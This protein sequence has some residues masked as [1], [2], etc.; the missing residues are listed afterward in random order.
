MDR[1]SAPD[2]RGTGRPSGVR[3]GPDPGGPAL[4]RAP[5]VLA[6]PTPDARVLAALECPLQTWLHHGASLADSFGIVDLQQR[7]TRV[8]DREEQ[9][10]IF[11]TAG[12]VVT[13][14]HEVHSFMRSGA[15]ACGSA[16]LSLACEGFH[17]LYRMS[18]PISSRT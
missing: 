7:G 17:E 10:R 3:P 8:P 6:Q 5:L 18:G 13:P 15:L 16:F 4:E 1:S 12:G 11:V 2:R 14:V 9:L